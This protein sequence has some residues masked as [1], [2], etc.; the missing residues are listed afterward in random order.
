M[1]GKILEGFKGLYRQAIREAKHLME[2]KDGLMQ[3]VNIA[4]YLGIAV[5]AGSIIIYIVQ[6]V[7]TTTG[8]PT[9]TYLANSSTNLLDTMDT[10]YSFLPIVA[11]AAIGAVAIGFVFGLIPGV[12][13]TNG[14]I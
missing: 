7:I 5:V 1:K 9:N 6:A 14:G 13:R 3:I 8:T 12:G 11:V 2:A 10:G 4:I